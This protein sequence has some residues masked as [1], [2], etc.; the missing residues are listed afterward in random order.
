[1]KKNKIFMSPVFGGTS[2]IL[3][4]KSQLDTLRKIQVTLYSVQTHYSFKDAKDL[5]VVRTVWQHQVK[6]T[7][8]MGKNG[9]LQA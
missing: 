2:T 3:E 1:M 7:A 9:S 5:K 4:G 8:N 6:M